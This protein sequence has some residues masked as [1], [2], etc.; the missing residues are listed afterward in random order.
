MTFSAKLSAAIQ[1]KKT[2]VLVGIDPRFNMIPEC[3]KQGVDSADLKA[4]A[5]V[6][7]TFS[8]RILDVIAPHVAC[9][10]PQLAFF[11][12]VGPYGMLALADVID[13][14]RELGLVVILDGKRNDIGSTAEGY[15]AAY[16]GEKSAW[17]GDAL[18][19]SPYLGEDSVQPFVKVAEQNDAGIFVLVKT[20]NPGGGMLQDLVADGKTIYQHTADWVEKTAAAFADSTGEKYGAVGAVVGATYPEQLAELRK[21]MPHAW[22]LVPGFG[23]QGGTVKDV[24][25]AFD[26][27]GLGAIINNSRGIIFA[28]S[29]KDYAGRFQDSEW[30]KAVETAVLDMK[31]QFKD[32]VR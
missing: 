14:A 9:I 16:L 7:R 18:T 12:A 24:A 8:C 13:Y 20:S 32:F 19:V 21:R 15:A 3:L 2:P 26:E 28:H 22:L 6:Y 17:R 1:A 30:E 10:K 25:H 31:E 11:E 27:N 5:D 4:V 23:A 29:R